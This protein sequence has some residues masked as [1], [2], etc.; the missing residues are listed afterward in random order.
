VVGADATLVADGSLSDPDS[1]IDPADVSGE[2]TLEIIGFDGSVNL[3]GSDGVTGGTE[4]ID[5]VTFIFDGT[6]DYDANTV[7]I[8]EFSVGGAAGRDQVDLNAILDVTEVFSSPNVAGLTSTTNTDSIM[9]LTTDLG[10]S[11]A[12]AVETAFGTTDVG[13][14]GSDHFIVTF[15]GTANAGDGAFNVWLWEDGSDQNIGASEL[16]LV[17]TLETPDT[18][19][20]D[21]FVI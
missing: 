3:Q 17:A 10:A 8:E 9:I 11:T 6:V 1:G 20:T 19:S 21:N 16:T 14:S 2:G 15:D 5:F 4:N 12:G 18:L 7:T 13:A